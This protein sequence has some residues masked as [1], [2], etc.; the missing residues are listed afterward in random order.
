MKG[1]KEP[2]GGRRQIV[3]EEIGRVGR[4]AAGKRLGGGAE[5]GV[6]E[7]G[8]GAELAEFFEHALGLEPLAH[9]RG[10][11]PHQGPRGISGPSG[12]FHQ[13]VSAGPAPEVAGT[14]LGVEEAEHRGDDAARPHEGPVARRSLRH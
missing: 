4:D 13:A 5:V 14:D 6:D 11:Q 2:V 8:V 10:V 1:F 3:W 9:R 7:L 12:P